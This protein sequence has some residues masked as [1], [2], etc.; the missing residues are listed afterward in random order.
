MNEQSRELSSATGEANIYFVYDPTPLKKGIAKTYGN[1]TTRSLYF[2]G[3]TFSYSQM[4]ISRSVSCCQ[5][6][7]I[8]SYVDGCGN[9]VASASGTF[10]F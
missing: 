4:E 5:L 3:A 6:T 1:S 7:N 8:N 10:R 9:S 2:V